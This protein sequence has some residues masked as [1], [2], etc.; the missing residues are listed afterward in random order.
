VTEPSAG[1]EATEVEAGVFT[2]TISN[3]RK[4]NA[5]DLTLCAELTS[6]VD[7]LRANP[8]VRAVIVTGSG[9][10]FCS[11]ADLPAVFGDIGTDVVEA[12]K[13]LKS[14]YDSFLGLR[15][16]T[17]PT[18]AAVQGDAVGAGLNIALCCDIAIAA[19]TANLATT[20]S[21][22]G[23]HPGGGCTAFLVEH[24]G[25]Q[26]ALR[27]LLEGGRLT[28]AEAYDW[29]L[30]AESVEQPY[31]A[32]LKLARRTASL[33][34]DLA[35]N[36]KQAVGLAANRDISAVLEFESWAQAATS[37]SPALRKMIER[38]S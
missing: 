9:G 29:G 26:R 37:N 5:L 1:I 17:V 2:L 32:A 38:L 36:I 6:A 21:S 10:T 13:R 34:P 25:Y 15:T 22:I 30:V 31:D 16:L 28:G 14:V 8:D 20:F 7:G 23:L 3:P 12:R 35:A 11:G 24:L 4:R 19:P 33:D 18:I 27:M